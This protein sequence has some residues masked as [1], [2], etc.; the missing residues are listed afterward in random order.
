MVAVAGCLTLAETEP[1]FCRS[2][3]GRSY[4]WVAVS[5]GGIFLPI[6][7]IF[8]HNWSLSEKCFSNVT[9]NFSFPSL[10]P[11]SFSLYLSAQRSNS[12]AYLLRPWRCRPH[13]VSC[14]LFIPP[15]HQTIC[16]S[17]LTALPLPSWFRQVLSPGWPPT[18]ASVFRIQLCSKNTSL[19]A[20]RFRFYS[21]ERE[22][23]TRERTRAGGEAEGEADSTTHHHHPK[24]GARCGTGSRTLRS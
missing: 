6:P 7:V 16:Y 1:F 2:P 10:K 19:N 23:S 15:P 3:E 20:Y 24:Q 21:F 22:Q 11:L 4:L 14:C 18:N 8:F 9:L 5:R 13:G 17:S 12:L